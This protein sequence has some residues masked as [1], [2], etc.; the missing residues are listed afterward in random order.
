MLKVGLALAMGEVLSEASGG[1]VPLAG[2][3]VWWRGSFCAVVAR[4]CCEG[5]STTKAADLQP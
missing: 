4:P 5:V 1:G 3:L 2:E